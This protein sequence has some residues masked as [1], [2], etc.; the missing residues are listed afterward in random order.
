MGVTFVPTHE[1]LF[2]E[3]ARALLAAAK[4]VIAHPGCNDPDCCTV[5][6]RNDVAVKALTGAIKEFE[7]HTF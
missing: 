4:D 2:R 6:R 3:A 1:E 5:A 7:K